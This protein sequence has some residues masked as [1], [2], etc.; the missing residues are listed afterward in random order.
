MTYF[1]E[2][3]G[4]TIWGSDIYKIDLGIAE[5]TVMIVM[6]KMF[7]GG[8]LLNNEICRRRQLPRSL[9][10]VLALFFQKTATGRALRA[11]ADDHQAAQVDRHSAQPHLGHRL[12]GG[13]F[14]CA[15][16]G[17]G[18]GLETGR[19]VFVVDDRIESLAGGDT[20]RLHLGTRRDYRRL[21]HRRRRKNCLKFISGRSD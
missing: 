10:A 1:L 3:F 11:V 15:G 7:D 21:D 9:V 18:V 19:A 6:E 20:G 2:G 14:R 4:Q 16:G 8:I 12:G 17:H 5:R 13:G